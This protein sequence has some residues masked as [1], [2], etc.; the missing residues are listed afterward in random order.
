MRDT[1]LQVNYCETCCIHPS[2]WKVG[3]IGSLH[4][5][6]PTLMSG[7]PGLEFA[8]RFIP[9]S[10][11]AVIVAEQLRPAPRGHSNEHLWNFGRA[12][13]GLCAW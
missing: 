12:G 3:T 1:V 6:G 11:P 4:S 7:V 10:S 13:S 8:A 9:G 5:P 2:A